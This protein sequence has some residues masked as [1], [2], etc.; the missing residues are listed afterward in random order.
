LSNR[1]KRSTIYTKLGEPIEVIGNAKEDVKKSYEFKVISTIQAEI[2]KD[3]ATRANREDFGSFISSLEKFLL[4]LEKNMSELIF[5]NSTLQESLLKLNGSTE[6]AEKLKAKDI[7]N[8]KQ[9][10]EKFRSLAKEHSKG[11]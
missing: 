4:L 11:V 8:Y 1:L 7:L 10:E 6:K 3:I 9:T 2:S 5:Q